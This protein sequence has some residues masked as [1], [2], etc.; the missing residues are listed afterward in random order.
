MEGIFDGLKVLDLTNVLSGP[1]LTRLLVE[2]GAEVIK[3]ELHPAG[4]IGRYLPWRRNGR[5][6]Y[7]VQQNRGKKSLFI[8][9][10]HPE[11]RALLLD[12]V[13]RVDVLVE[14]FAP[15]A[16]D[17][18]GLGW[19]VVSARNPRLVMCSIS[20]FGQTGPL[21]SRPG[22][23]PIAQAYTGTMSMVGERDGAPAMMAYS[24]GDVM[25]GVHGMAGVCAALY[26]RERTGKGQRVE[27][28]LVDTYVTCHE[29]NYQ[30]TSASDGEFVARRNGSLHPIVPGCGAFPVADGHVAV[31]VLNDNQWAGF[32]RAAGKPELVTDPRFVSAEQRTA[33]GGEFNRLLSEWLAAQPGRDAV[34]EA[35]T[36][37]RVPVGPVLSI[38]EALQNEHLRANRTIRTVHDAR[39]GDLDIPGMPIRFSSFPAERALDAAALGEHNEDIV[40]GFLGRDR[41]AYDAL[42][43]AGV[44]RYE[45]E[46]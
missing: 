1:T 28:S 13:D 37:E 41:A 4:D 16:I 10:K 39:M 18:L 8:N 29:I 5:S 33:N 22:Y 6:G 3:A 9:G 45:P 12:L 26:H 44:L 42:T 23:D 17:R 46:S 21:A 14:N 7:F 25:T 24:P 2:M 36:A 43:A 11:G 20:G 30:A 38:A 32:C 15:G 19:D 40:C 34:V 35:L 31:A 27:V